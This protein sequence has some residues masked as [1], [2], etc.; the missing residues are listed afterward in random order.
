MRRRR[1]QTTHRICE[2]ADQVLVIY[3]LLIVLRITI[4]VNEGGSLVYS[5][6]ETILKSVCACIHVWVKAEESANHD[7]SVPVKYEYHS[8][9]YIPPELLFKHIR[10]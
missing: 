5:V 1:E 10:P 3:A 4:R 6:Q 2:E 7:G 9:G 8:T